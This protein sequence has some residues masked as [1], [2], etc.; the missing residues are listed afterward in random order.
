[1]DVATTVHVNWDSLLRWSED[2]KSLTYIDNRGGTENIWGQPIDG[3]PPKQLTDFKDREVFSYDWSRD[4]SLVISKGVIASD[5]VLI[6]DV[7]R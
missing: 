7:G 4:G 1:F 2:S 6:T 5:V 3:G